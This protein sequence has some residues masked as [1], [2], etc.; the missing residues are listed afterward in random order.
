MVRPTKLRLHYCKIKSGRD[1]GVG[2]V[3]AGFRDFSNHIS[4]V[5]WLEEQT[6]SGIS[7]VVLAIRSL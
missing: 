7:V 2:D 3:G 5:H 6:S 4:L 1:V